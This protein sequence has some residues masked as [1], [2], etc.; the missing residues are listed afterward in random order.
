MSTAIRETV[1]GGFA[2]LVIGNQGRW[3]SAG[4]DLGALLA[5]AEAGNRPAVEE[6][7]KGF[8]KMTTSLRAAPFPVVAAPFGMTLGGGCE[9]MLYSDAV[10][11]DAELSTG[12][13]E[14]KVGADAVRR[15]DHRNAGVRANARL[16]PGDDPFAS[17]RERVRVDHL[18]P[19]HGF[20][21]GSAA[22]GIL[23]RRRRDHD[24]Q[25]GGWLG[26][27]KDTL[28]AMVA[29]GYELPVPR[30]VAVLGERRLR[31]ADANRRAAAG[32]GKLE[33]LR[34][35]NGRGIGA[36]SD[37]RRPRGPPSGSCRKRGC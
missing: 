17:G 24:E 21:A 5:D 11:A 20:G 34:R 37:R 2:G 28:L 18:G 4:A 19:R 31:A 26:D 13:V 35:G 10:Q 1:P 22:A 9:T 30:Q 3:F 14:L 7:I 29:A 33:R 36:D 25:R 23:A 32:G 12:L 16:E 15:R 8:Q 27:A 6:M